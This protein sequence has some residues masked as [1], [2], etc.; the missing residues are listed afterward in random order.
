M[1]RRHVA[2][3]TFLPAVLPVDLADLADRLADAHPATIV[4]R[5]APIELRFADPPTLLAVLSAARVDFFED[6]DAQADDD[7]VDTDDLGETDDDDETTADDGAEDVTNTI[8]ILLGLADDDDEA[9]A[10]YAASRNVD[11]ADRLAAALLGALLERGL[12]ELVTPRARP[13][14]EGKLA[15]LLAHDADPHAIADGLADHEGVAELYADDAEL[16]ALLRD[17]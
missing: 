11:D 15:H 12:L 4:G 13:A 16:A 3:F 1:Q 17:A 10:A 8:E 7:P 2:T 5:A 6:L 14:V 9:D